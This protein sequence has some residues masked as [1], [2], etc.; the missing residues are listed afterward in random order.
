M[1]VSALNAKIPVL[2]SSA[3]T[4]SINSNLCLSPLWLGCVI[5]FHIFRWPTIHSE[6]SIG[7]TKYPNLH[8]L[9]NAYR[10]A[11]ST[12]DT[13]QTHYSLCSVREKKTKPKQN[14]WF[15]LR[16]LCILQCWKYSDRSVLRSFAPYLPYKYHTF[17]LSSCFWSLY[18][19]LIGCNR[20]CLLFDYQCWNCTCNRTK[21]N[22]SVV[23]KKEEKSEQ[24][25]NKLYYKQW[26][27]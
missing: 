6:Y 19:N 5:N 26:T 2:M 25:K 18:S 27:C 20:I 13:L 9:S 14:N 17:S 7:W 24:S 22:P 3:R 16:V 10:N 8:F 23:R 15:S 21:P 1:I 12:V 4:F 11:S